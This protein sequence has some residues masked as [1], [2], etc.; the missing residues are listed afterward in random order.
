MISLV[1]TED[2]VAQYKQSAIVPL[3]FA[4]SQSFQLFNFWRRSGKQPVQGYSKIPQG[5][6][7]NNADLIRDAQGYVPLI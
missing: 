2:N 3:G 6:T 7:S 4:A 5:R 1:E